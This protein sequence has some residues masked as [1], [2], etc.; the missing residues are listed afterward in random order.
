MLHLVILGEMGRFSTLE[1]AFQTASA[2]ELPASGGKIAESSS[3]ARLQHDP[4]H[5]GTLVSHL[6]LWGPQVRPF[7]P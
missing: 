2:G 3:S 4:K 5:L 1:L 7:G 6:G